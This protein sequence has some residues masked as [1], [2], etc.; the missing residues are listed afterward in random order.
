MNTNEVRVYFALDGDEFDPDEVTI[1]LGIEPT[2]TK[3]KGESVSGRITKNSSWQF[4]TENIVNEYI[5]VFKITRDLINKLKPKKDLINQAKSRFNV[6]ARLEV[7]LW[8][9]INEY[10]STPAIGFEVDTIEFLGQIGAFID[11]DTY[12]H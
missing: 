5:N 6:S 4:S 7:V 2:S 9:S 1:F 12:I 11:I 3:R 10:H 8:L